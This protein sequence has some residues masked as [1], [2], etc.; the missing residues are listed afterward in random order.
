MDLRRG[1]SWR[2]LVLSFAGALLVLAGIGLEALNA[3]SLISYHNAAAVH[4][5]E[6]IELGSDALPEAGQHG[7]MARLVGTPKVVE[8]PHDPQFNQSAN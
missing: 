5:G 3:S 7:Y 2:P 1:M 4:G 6:V 8:A